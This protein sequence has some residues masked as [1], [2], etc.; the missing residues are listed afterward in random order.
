[1]GSSPYTPTGGLSS[2]Q[3]LPQD[4]QDAAT[5]VWEAARGYL[6]LGMPLQAFGQLILRARIAPL[7]Q[8]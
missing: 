1:M 7:T 8:G 6:N 4:G 3:P 5:L 2:G